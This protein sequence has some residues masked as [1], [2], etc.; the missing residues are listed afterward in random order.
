MDGFILSHGD[1]SDDAMFV[2]ASYFP[3]HAWRS[4][5]FRAGPVYVTLRIGDDGQWKPTHN[6]CG[7][8]INEAGFNWH[9]AYTLF[10]EGV[11]PALVQVCVTHCRRTPTRWVCYGTV[12][13]LVVNTIKANMGE[14]PDCLPH[15]LYDVF[16]AVS[17]RM[18]V[19]GTLPPPEAKRQNRVNDRLHFGL[20]E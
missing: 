2:G 16:R 9:T 11:I 10:R 15:G 1:Y 17:C 13:M 3:S 7:R 14:Q 4:N 12:V 6:Y 20:E 5:L 19:D 18:S 8:D